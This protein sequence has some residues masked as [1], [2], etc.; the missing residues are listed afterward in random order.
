[1]C[2]RWGPLKRADAETLRWDLA[3][4]LLPS[5]GSSRQIVVLRLL[6]QGSVEG[7][8]VPAMDPFVS[9][10]GWPVRIHH[11]DHAVF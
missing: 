5:S 7:Q 10:L 2:F 11:Q 4:H 8:S 3:R 6:A 9:G 1:M